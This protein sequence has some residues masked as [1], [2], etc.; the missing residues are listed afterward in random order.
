MIARKTSNSVITA[1]ILG[2]MMCGF[3]AD[4]KQSKGST[5]AKG[6]DRSG[7]TKKE[8][9]AAVA[10]VQ[11]QLNVLTKALAAG[12]AKAL[13]VL[14]TEDG[15]YTDEDGAE[16]KGRA[17]L[18]QRFA[19]IFAQAG[20]PVVELVPDSTR[21]LSKYVV[22]TEGVV[23]GKQGAAAGTPQTRYSLIFSRQGGQWL[24]TSATETALAR[25][26][27][28]PN[29]ENNLRELSW[30][31]GKWSAERNGGWVHMTAE[32]AADKN[33][34]TCKYEVK[35]SANSPE[36]DS[37]QVIGWDPR[38][39]RP[40]SWHF[41]SNG[42]FGYGNWSRQNSQWIVES[43]GVERDGS[44]TGATNILTFNNPDSFNWQSVQR[45]LNGVAFDD[46]APLKVVRL[47]K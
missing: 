29:A 32:W 8:D 26:A 16:Y 27:A 18:E 5:Q 35:K 43:T 31:I 7:A 13:S 40:I 37:R 9:D 4:A 38:T 21:F 47:G 25:E 2:I 34:I 24:I 17:A 12:D 36:I 15:T 39:A 23:R 3:P 6:A 42:G 45:S 11:A 10:A 46:T 1:I 30:L 33:F 44:T 22:L 20:K 41:D 28:Q 19:T 14:W